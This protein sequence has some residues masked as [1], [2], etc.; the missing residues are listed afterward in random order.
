MKSEMASL[1]VAFALREMQD[2]VGA[3]VEKVFQEESQV[4][5]ALHI[6]GKGSRTLVAGPGMFFL[7]ER[8]PLHADTPTSFAMH[9]RKHLKGKRIKSV[10]QHGFDRIVFIEFDGM[11]LVFEL[12]RDSNA[13][14]VSRDG[15]IQSV[16]RHEEWKDRKLK[17]GEKYLPPLSSPDI[18]AISENEFISAL[19]SQKQVVAF[20]AREFSLGGAYAEEVCLRANIDKA[21]V[22]A[23][24]AEPEARKIYSSAK[25]LFSEKVSPEIVLAGEAFEDV[26]PFPLKRY[27]GAPSKQFDSFNSALEEYFLGGPAGGSK[28]EKAAK[29]EAD[30]KSAKLLVRQK[31]QEEAILRLEGEEKEALFAA[32]TIRP[33]YQELDALINMVRASGMKNAMRA[34]EKIKNIDEKAKAISVDVGGGKIVRLSIGISLA[35][36]AGKY[37]DEAKKIRG[38]IARAK[39]ALEKTKALVDSGE[40][41]R[42]N[43][44]RQKSVPQK[45]EWYHGFRW[46]ISSTGFVVVGGKDASTNETLVKRHAEKEDLVFHTDTAGSP[47]VIVK[48]GGRDIDE[49]TISEAAQFAACNS[50][51]WKQ[52]VGS[53]DVF[54]VSPD[55]VTKK[56]QSGEYM[57]HGSFM[58]YG[59]KNWVKAELR[60]AAGFAGGAFIFGPVSSVSSRTGK[61]VVFGP[62]TTSAAELAKR[63][64]AELFG[65]SSKEDQGILRK[66]GTESLQKM[67]P[68]GCGEIIK[69]HI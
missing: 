1:D 29:K 53:L 45:K 30:A 49:K 42:A 28:E 63:I 22:C 26:V 15:T 64:K 5:L 59:K 58:I 66:T 34:S 46:F 60:I 61:Y 4:H 56:A 57:G 24:L 32:E 52:G 62:G 67:V 31:E 48:S 19:K 50:R 39:D 18:S 36:N 13:I 47:F 51:A 41:T 69:R 14:L 55:Q 23:A 2:A 20:L 17:R 54:Y 44:A 27:A 8:T 16:M 25:S 9:L 33:R 68:Y 6:S 65:M 37:Y 12:F 40:E 10:A 21:K 3:R 11:L 35:E 43:D 38:K 7:S